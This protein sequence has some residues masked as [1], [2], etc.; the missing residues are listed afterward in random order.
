M[1]HIDTHQ[2]KIMS[3]IIHIYWVMVATSTKVK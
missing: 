2:G 3:K 1:I